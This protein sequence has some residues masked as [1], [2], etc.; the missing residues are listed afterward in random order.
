MERNKPRK[1]EKKEDRVLC[2]A[3]H[4]CKKEESGET[5]LVTMCIAWRKRQITWL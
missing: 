5:E 1:Q 2:I 3:G 4:A